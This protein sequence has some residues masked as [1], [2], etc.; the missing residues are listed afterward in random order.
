MKKTVHLILGAILH[1]LW[2]GA[3]LLPV[4]GFTIL[5]G[6]ILQW[7]ADKGAAWWAGEIAVALV[8]WAL[9]TLHDLT[10]EKGV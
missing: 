7:P 6:L 3:V 1:S 10:S 5:I 8:L 9:C 4:M 2:I